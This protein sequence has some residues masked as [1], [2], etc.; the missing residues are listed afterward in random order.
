MRATKISF[1]LIKKHLSCIFTLIFSLLFWQ[2]AVKIFNIPEYILPSPTQIV[3]SAIKY[4]QQ[5]IKHSL[6]TLS[7]IL[8]GFTLGTMV[9]FI[10]S[11]GILYS[12]VLEKAI[13]PLLIFF[14]VTPKVALAPLFLIWFGYGLLP[15]ILITALISFFP[16]IVNTVKGLKSIDA[17]LIDLM[18]SLSATKIQILTKIRIPSSLPYLFAGL[19]IGITLAVVGAVVGEFV[20][21]SKGLGYV[22]M[23]SNANLETSL[24]FASIVILSIIG[25]VLFLLINL[26]ESLCSWHRPVDINI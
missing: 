16:I 18:Y 25:I 13:Y 12:K 21:A 5:L 22:I 17:E 14:Q 8:I 19:K 4:Q 9:A 26:I 7:E 15:K 6:I 20:G 10:I 24:V 23:L 11:L 3:S 1:S 2:W